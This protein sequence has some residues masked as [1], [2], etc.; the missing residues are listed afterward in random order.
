[1]NTILVIL[2]IAATVALF[3]RLLYL[4]SELKALNVE[5]DDRVAEISD[6]R[7]K[8]EALQNPVATTWVGTSNA[9]TTAVFK[10]KKGAKK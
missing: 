5:M 8:V 10:A 3:I 1:M 6:L 4:D 2:L 7:R 9:P